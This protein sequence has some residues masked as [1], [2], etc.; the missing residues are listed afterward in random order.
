MSYIIHT[1]IRVEGAFK[2]VAR[3]DTFIIDFLA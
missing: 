2:I 3:G 1:L